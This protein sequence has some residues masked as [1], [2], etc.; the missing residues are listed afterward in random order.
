MACP[1]SITLD[2]ERNC[3]A[4]V[5]IDGRTGPATDG[6]FWSSSNTQV[7]ATSRW[8]ITG[9]ALGSAIIS[10]EGIGLSASTTVNVVADAIYDATFTPVS[11]T[12]LS[13][14]HPAHGGTFT[15]SG[16]R[17]TLEMGGTTQ[18]YALEFPTAT[19][20]RA[21]ISGVSSYGGF[22]FTLDLDMA[23]GRTDFAGREI[24]RGA[25][26]CSGGYL[27]AMNRRR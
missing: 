21:R 13:P 6:V 11:N 22:S 18:T 1:A 20:M 23:E 10:G 8:L 15:I 16:G 27:W 3:S 14:I 25:D 17:G 12:C 24:A 5:T 2:E 4:E 9:V 19:G 7:V 26:G